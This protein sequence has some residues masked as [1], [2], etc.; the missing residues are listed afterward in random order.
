MIN[1]IWCLRRWIITSEGFH[2]RSERSLHH[3]A[4]ALALK[5]TVMMPHTSGQGLGSGVCGR[6]IIIIKRERRGKRKEKREE[7]VRFQSLLAQVSVAI[8]RFSEETY[9][10][11]FSAAARCMVVKLQTIN[12]KILVRQ[13]VHSGNQLEEHS[14]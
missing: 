5:M 8:S 7:N 4:T 14:I 9:A 13:A 3:F 6:L 10:I 1:N 2:V 11:F 12:G